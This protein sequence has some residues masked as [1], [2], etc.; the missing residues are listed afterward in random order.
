MTIQ[1]NL[2]ESK[3]VKPGELQDEPYLKAASE[4]AALLNVERMVEQLKVLINRE[5]EKYDC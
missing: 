3:F 4:K 5:Y 2:R 1:H